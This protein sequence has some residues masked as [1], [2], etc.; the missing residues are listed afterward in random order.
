MRPE[1]DK[2]VVPLN[3]VLHAKP[4]RL[5]AV[6]ALATHN[7]YGIELEPR[8]DARKFN[9]LLDHTW[10]KLVVKRMGLHG[11]H[12]QRAITVA[13]QAHIVTVRGPRGEF[14]LNGLA[15]ALEAD[16]NSLPDGCPESRAS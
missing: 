3:T 6:Y 4:A 5:R 15:D 8:C 11:A 9:A 13:S 14:R 16:F 2:F 12:F 7:Q 10:Q 1:L